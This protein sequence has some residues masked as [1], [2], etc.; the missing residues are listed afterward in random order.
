MSAEKYP[1]SQTRGFTLVEL[2]IA[3]AITAILA[4]MAAPSFSDLIETQRVKSAATDLLIVLNRARS[5]ALKRNVDVTLSPPSANWADGW[6]IADPI[7]GDL[8]EKHDA[9]RNVTITGPVS[10]IYQSSGRVQGSATVTFA[11]SATSVSS[12]RCVTLDL[13]GRPSIKAASC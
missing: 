13:S 10:V 11:I 5:E 9:V 3:L 7:T 1:L 4:G 12:E 8:I 6:Q 2:L